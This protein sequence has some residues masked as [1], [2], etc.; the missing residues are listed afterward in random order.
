MSGLTG[1]LLSNG[2]DLSNVFM[3]K[4]TSLILPNGTNIITG[5]NTFVGNVDL[6]GSLL[7]GR[8]DGYNFK[9]TLTIKYPIGYTIQPSST[10]TP[11]NT[12]T[13]INVT[14][15][16]GTW[17]VRGD[18]YSSTTTGNYTTGSYISCV[19]GN[20]NITYLPNT[21]FIY[22]MPSTILISGNY[23]IPILNAIA[24]VSS[25]SETMTITVNISM[26][27]TGTSTSRILYSATKIA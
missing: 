9:T 14:L 5:V 24:V 1:Y 27:N 4:D 12:T 6:S 25:S 21:T 11:P 20:A 15:Y 16:L 22:Q 23:Q 10:P 13:T 3:N 19:L 18:I 2:T 17:L 26:T 7:Y 8:N